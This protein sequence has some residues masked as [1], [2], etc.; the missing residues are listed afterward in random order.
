MSQ[1]PGRLHVV[2][3]YTPFGR[4]AVLVSFNGYLLDALT[5]F[6]TFGRTLLKQNRDLDS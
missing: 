3:R 4:I 2:T 5:L 1:E 6:C